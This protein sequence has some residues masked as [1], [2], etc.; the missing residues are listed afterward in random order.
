MTPFKLF[1][2]LALGYYQ[3]VI[4]FYGEYV[5]VRVCARVRCMYVCVCQLPISMLLNHQFVSVIHHLTSK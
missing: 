3:S 2:W 5:C 4:N 1:C